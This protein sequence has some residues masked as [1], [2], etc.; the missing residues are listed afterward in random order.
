MVLDV[1]LDFVLVVEEIFE[2]F[3]FLGVF[4]DIFVDVRN[5]DFLNC[6]ILI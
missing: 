6:G 4:F 3:V 2:V 5:M 1:D